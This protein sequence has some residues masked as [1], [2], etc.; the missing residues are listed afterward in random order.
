LPDAVPPPPGGLMQVTLRMLGSMPV[1]LV[2]L[3]AGAGAAA[4]ALCDRASLVSLAPWSGR[5]TLAPLSLWGALRASA[6]ALPQP[7]SAPARCVRA[8]DRQTDTGV[9]MGRCERGCAC[10]ATAVLRSAVCLSIRASAWLPCQL[11]AGRCRPN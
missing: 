9:C 4:L 8:L 11:S 7:G 1:V 5:A 6:L 10:A 3:P 2:P